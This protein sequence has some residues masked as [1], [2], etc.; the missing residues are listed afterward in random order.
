MFPSGLKRICDLSFYMTFASMIGGLFGVE[1]LILT[2]PLFALSAFLSAS[3]APRGPIKYMGLL[4]LLFL[5]LIVP[6]T[7]TN[8][9]LFMP[10][11][12]Y[13]VLA[14][15]KADENVSQFEY[16]PVFYAFLIIFGFF[17]FLGF[18]MTW[19][20][21]VTGM[22]IETWLFAATF[23][24]SSILFMR[25]ARH[26]ESVLKQMR[27]KVMNATTLTVVLG[28]TAG[29]VLFGTDAFLTF[30]W[31]IIGFIWSYLIAPILNVLIW[32]FLVILTFIFRLFGLDAA[33]DTIELG[34]PPILPEEEVFEWEEVEAS[35]L[36]TFVSIMLIACAII[37]IVALLWLLFKWLNK[38]TDAIFIG[39]DGVEEERFSLD[40]G[41]AQKKK[42]WGRRYHENP[43]REVYRRFL[44]DVNKSGIDVRQHS[45]S[46]DVEALVATKFKSKTSDALRAEYIRVRYGEVAY[47]KADVKRV[48][49]LYRRFKADVDKK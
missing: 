35:S 49:A 40:A 20:M 43:V 18:L 22:P 28:A 19:G 26:D 47:T 25:M 8:M 27:F 33:F 48:K 7:L 41:D 44:V 10:P 21:G 13:M 29:I 42:R 31:R 36:P 2:L 5:F 1:Q 11:C 37:V 38:K 3:L 39:E 15:P 34:E 23:L 14:L 30:V 17:A 24:F 45:T 16:Y 4:P 12:L 32:L 9:I 46:A 6:F